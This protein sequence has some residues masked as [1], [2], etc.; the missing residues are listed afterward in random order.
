MRIAIVILLAVLTI[1]GGAAAENSAFVTTR[2]REF[3]GPDG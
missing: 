3:I 1:G 2:G